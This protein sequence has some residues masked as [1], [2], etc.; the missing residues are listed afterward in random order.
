M[1]SH[2][3]FIDYRKTVKKKKRIKLTTPMRMLKMFDSNPSNW[4]Y[5]F[6]TPT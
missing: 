4:F 1:E 3:K 2:I 6:C 5:Y